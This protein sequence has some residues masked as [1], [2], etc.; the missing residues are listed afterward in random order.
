MI[1]KIFPNGEF[2]VSV[3]PERRLKIE[4]SLSKAGDWELWYRHLVRSCLEVFGV[5]ETIRILQSD[6]AGYDERVMF[7]V[8]GGDGE[9][10]LPIEFTNVLNSHKRQK[11][12]RRGSRGISTH[13]RRQVRNAA[14]YLETSTSRPTLS[15]LTLTCPNIEPSE[16][17]VFM[18]QH[19]GRITHTFFKWLYSRLKKAGLPT[20]WVGVA[21]IQTK[22][23]Q[24]SNIPYPHLHVVFKGRFHQGPWAIA[25][26]EFRKEWRKL[27]RST[28][29][30]SLVA[31]DQEWRACEN[32][33]RVEKSVEAYLG[34][35]L[36][37]GVSSSGEAIPAQWRDCLPSNW[38][39]ISQN[40]KN[41]IARETKSGKDIGNIITAIIENDLDGFF[42]YVTPISVDW[43]DMKLFLGYAGKL[44][45]PGQADILKALEKSRQR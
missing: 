3:L 5:Q 2:T 17:R 6:R 36:S 29:L 31:D 24:K 1:G 7:D 19:W 4:R 43:G 35:Y 30:P 14:F 28:G 16:F 44:S 20:E 40:I 26:R 38:H 21:E 45:R 34:K 12:V 33:Q 32:V 9:D 22:R 25:P 39:F 11:A 13:A 8:L 18:Q 10:G 23:M 15:F 42:D 37:K 41:W 27:L